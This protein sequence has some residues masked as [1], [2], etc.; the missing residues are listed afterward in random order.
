VLL[1][2]G[3]SGL[4][5]AIEY[6]PDCDA[7]EHAVNETDD[8]ITLERTDPG[9]DYG[10]DEAR[11]PNFLPHDSSLRAKDPAAR[12]PL[13]ARANRRSCL[14]CSGGRCTYSLSTRQPAGPR[15]SFRAMPGGVWEGR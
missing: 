14:F 6:Q 12:T 7:K 1:A 2:D 15:G 10:T 3:G 5:A 4:H 13:E 8:D 11:K 9:A